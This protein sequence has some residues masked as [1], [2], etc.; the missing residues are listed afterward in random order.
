MF[1]RSWLFCG[2][3]ALAFAWN[4]LEG[5]ELKKRI[6]R[7]ALRHT[8][9]RVI[10]PQ[11]RGAEFLIIREFYYVGSM[12]ALIFG[13]PPPHIDNRNLNPLWWRRGLGFGVPD[14]RRAGCWVRTTVESQNRQVSSYK[15]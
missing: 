9:A 2:D 7:G 15:P 3:P 14:V 1:L 12:L 8:D 11:K 10:C 5:L 6:V 13:P 4:R